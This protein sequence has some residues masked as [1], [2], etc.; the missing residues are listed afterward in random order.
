MEQNWYSITNLKL[1]IILGASLLWIVAGWILYALVGVSHGPKGGIDSIGAALAYVFFWKL[2][3]YVPPVLVSGISFCLWLYQ[4]HRKAIIWLL[5]A[6][7]VLIILAIL[8][9][10]HFRKIIN[11][12]EHIAAGLE[13]YEAWKEYRGKWRLEKWTESDCIG[14]YVKDIV[15]EAVSDYRSMYDEGD[16]DLKLSYINAAMEAHYKE[17]PGVEGWSYIPDVRDIIPLRSDGDDKFV[18]SNGELCIVAEHF[19]RDLRR[20]HWY[21]RYQ[22]ESSAIVEWYS[23]LPMLA[24]F[25]DDG[26]MDIVITV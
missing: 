12:P 3:I 16:I 7:A 10:T 9:K 26:T 22:F 5:A 15:S 20:D 17:L 24:I 13:T 19:K 14:D 18:L 1:L 2:I 21:D 11:T 4:N 8:Y 6:I 25:Y 23:W